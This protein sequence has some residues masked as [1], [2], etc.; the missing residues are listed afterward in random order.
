MPSKRFFKFLIAGGTAAALNF[1]SR[2]IF[3]EFMPFEYAI[4]CAFFVGLTSGFILNKTLVFGPT[5][6]TVRTQIGAYVA[7]NLIA[8]LQTWIVTLLMA[9]A[10]IP[11]LGVTIGEA[12]AHL[13]GIVVPACTSYFGHKYL[14]FK[15]RVS[16]P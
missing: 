11:S 2:F 6:N 3:S 8:L 9:S 5:D 13:C 12:L 10:L 14:T 7:V 4:V 16:V 1:G 15:E